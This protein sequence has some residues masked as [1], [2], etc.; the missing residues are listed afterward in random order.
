MSFGK[1]FWHWCKIPPEPPK[2]RHKKLFASSLL[3]TMI[4]ISLFAALATFSGSLMIG[5]GGSFAL[6]SVANLAEGPSYIQNA[7]YQ[8]VAEANNSTVQNYELSMK[9]IQDNKSDA[10]ML[11]GESGYRSDDLGSINATIINLGERD[12]TATAI[13]IY[14]G[15]NLFASIDG[16]FIVRAHSI[17]IVNFQ[18]YNLK[19]LSKTDAQQVI[20]FYSQQG[21]GNETI[22]A[23]RVMYTII[24]KTSDDVTASFEK[25]LFPTDYFS[26]VSS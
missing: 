23:G 8:T 21:G 24:L 13:E 17:G 11:G 15:A 18:V 4:G 20:Q 2:N 25:F 9:G 5:Q 1:N 19:E 14:R 6:L 3:C 10:L 26:Q 12:M 16:P 22:F 7:T